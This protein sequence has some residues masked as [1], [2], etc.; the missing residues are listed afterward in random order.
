MEK[1]SPVGQLHKG[2]C[3][4]CR[5][6]GDRGR[7][8]AWPPGTGTHTACVSEEVPRKHSGMRGSGRAQKSISEDSSLSTGWG[9]LVAAGAMGL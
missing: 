4:W 3:D 5:D 6:R 7:S 8:K 9:P 2:G 1:G